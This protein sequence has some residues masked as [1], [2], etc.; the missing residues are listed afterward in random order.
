MPD[1]QR[2]PVERWSALAAQLIEQ[3]WQVW[4]IAPV[5]EQAFCEQICAGLN[6][7]QQME[8]ANLSGRLAWDDK[9]DLIGLSRAVLAQETLTASS[10]RP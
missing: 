5:K 4:L 2:W 6:R 1:R 9:I 8:I 10:V 3:G 7:E